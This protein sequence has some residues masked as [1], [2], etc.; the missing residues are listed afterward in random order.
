[1]MGNPNNEKVGAQL[2]DLNRKTEIPYFISDEIIVATAIALPQKDVATEEE[3][4][5]ILVTI[6]QLN[7]TNHWS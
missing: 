3:S 4:I 7:P 1:M 2:Q 5:E 6:T